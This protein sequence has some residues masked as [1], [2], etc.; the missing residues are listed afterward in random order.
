MHKNKFDQVSPT[1]YYNTY[2][3]LRLMTQ[4][5]DIGLNHEKIINIFVDRFH[6]GQALA[7]LGSMERASWEK[8]IKLY[9]EEK[10]ANNN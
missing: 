6:A 9:E 4:Y 1:F 10:K 3:G 2:K 7:D 5:H 8:Y